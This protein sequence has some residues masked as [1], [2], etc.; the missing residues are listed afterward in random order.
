MELLDHGP[1]VALFMFYRMLRLRLGYD[2]P[3]P[4]GCIRQAAMDPYSPTA[5]TRRLRLVM[6]FGEP[7]SLVVDGR[8]TITATRIVGDV[9]CFMRAGR[10]YEVRMRMRCV[11]PHRP[12]W[13]PVWSE[14]QIDAGGGMHELW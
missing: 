12:S 2:G 10:T 6:R 5:E 9:T 7:Q 1:H 4:A 3:L 13:Q 11:R 8:R 14:Y